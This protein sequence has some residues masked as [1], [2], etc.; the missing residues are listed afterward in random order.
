MSQEI[1][2][3]KKAVRPAR[4][5]DIEGVESQPETSSKTDEKLLKPNPPARMESRLE[6]GTNSEQ[7]LYKPVRPNRFDS[8]EETRYN[9]GKRQF[10]KPQFPKKSDGY[11]KP[12]KSSSKL[13]KILEAA[14][15]NGEIFK[16]GD[17]IM[18]RSP[19]CSQVEVEI[20]GFYRGANGSIFA[21]FVPEESLP[22]WSWEKG[23]IRAELLKQPQGS[24]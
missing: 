1:I 12:R 7:K 17:K 5:E 20:T 2:G 13:D 4:P 21:Q 16:P 24:N 10:S 3:I 8:Q 15:A 11:E 6:T 23:C 19:W 14:N 22:N 18:V 9:F